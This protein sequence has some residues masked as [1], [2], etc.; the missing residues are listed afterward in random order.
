MT[1]PELVIKG[2]IDR[3]EDICSAKLYGR[4]KDIKVDSMLMNVLSDTKEL[5]LFAHKYTNI[6]PNAINRE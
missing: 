4:G 6:Y 3:Y 2:I 5:A 1:N